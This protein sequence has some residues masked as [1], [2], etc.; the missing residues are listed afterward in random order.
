LE[1]IR[2]AWRRVVGLEAEKQGL[3]QSMMAWS[4]V[5]GLGAE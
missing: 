4:R 2:R 1:Q 5:V 3:E